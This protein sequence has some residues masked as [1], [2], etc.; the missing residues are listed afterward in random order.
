MMSF[1]KRRIAW[2]ASAALVV[3]VV[4]WDQNPAGAL[5]TSEARE[6]LGKWTLTLESQRG[7]QTMELEIKDADGTLEAQIGGGFGGDEP[8]EITSISKSD[9][10]LKLSYELDFN[11]QAVPV[12]LTIKLDG[13]KLAAALS[14]AGGQFTIEGTGAK[15]VEG[16]PE[17]LTAEEAEARTAAA[18]SSEG[19]SR[20]R[21]RR[22]RGGRTSIS[23]GDKNVYITFTPVETSHVDFKVMDSL[24]DGSFV[25]FTEASATQLSTDLDLKFGDTLIK[26]GNVS[27]N[28]RGRYS[29]WVKRVGSDWRLFFNEKADVW[30][31]QYDPETDA[32]DI[33]LNYSSSA[34]EAEKFTVELKQDGD[35]G[36][37]LR[38]AWGTHEWT[39]EFT[40]A[41]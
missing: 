17:V 25:R 1:S 38:I 24:T 19:R 8:N 29:I 18:A 13:E 27:P 34:T 28:Y 10:G 14:F 36:G 30:G 40:L 32:A 33:A 37:T 23:F 20:R 9:D 15:A 41:E 11:G 3:W 22:A 35:S 7:E 31:T 26:Y 12:D 5:E 39:T 16:E 6:Y 4:G 2:F 21:G